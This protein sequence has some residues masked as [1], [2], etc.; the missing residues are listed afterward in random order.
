MHYVKLCRL[1]YG[2]YCVPP[3]MMLCYTLRLPAFHVIFT[4]EVVPCRML[5][6]R[7]VDL[8]V[9]PLF[10]AS[11]SQSNTESKLTV[12]IFGNGVGKPRLPHTP[13]PSIKP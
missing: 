13:L 1:A 12:E 8:F 9:V 10:P 5:L 3:C 4:Y 2:Y 6:H 7:R 11:D